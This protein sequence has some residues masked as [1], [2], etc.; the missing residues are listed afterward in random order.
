MVKAVI[1]SP[2][3]F[4][5]T[6]PTGQILNRF[7][8]D[9]AKID[10]LLPSDILV[11]ALQALQLAGNLVVI[12]IGNPW[13]VLVIVPFVAFT[14]VLYRYHVCASRELKRL[15]AINASPLYDQFADTIRGIATI[16]NQGQEQ[17]MEDRLYR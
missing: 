9:T 11:T 16:R 14:S 17:A 5:D 4:F 2:V 3:L 13:M 6:N 12:C 1:Q 7:T 8:Q 15:D 10:D